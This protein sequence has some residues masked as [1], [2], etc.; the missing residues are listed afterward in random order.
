[1]TPNLIDEVLMNSKPFILF[2]LVLSFAV[3][4]SSLCVG[5]DP[6]TALTVKNIAFSREEG[7]GEKVSLFCDQSCVPELSS[8]EGDNPRVVMDMKGVSLIQTKTRNVNTGGT[9]V[10]RVRSYL[11]KQTKILRVVLDMEPSKYYTVRPMQDPSGNTYVLTV[12]EAVS[13]SEQKPGGGKD[14]KGSTLSQE[15]RITILSP[16]LKPGDQGGKL[17][18]AAPSPEK[19][20][21]VKAAKDAP[22]VDQGRSQLNAGEFA[23]AIDT[24]TRIIVADPQN[25]LSYRL[26]GNAYDN[27][28][29]RKKALADW[30]RAARLGDT[31]IQ[32]YLD[33][34]KVKWRGKPAP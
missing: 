10:K 17:Q 6:K 15:K 2:L 28:A 26:R 7:R 29:D 34:L 18:E 13:P 32:S 21:V 27:L 24:F 12:Y 19:R 9:L 4:V 1:M 25:S 14:A 11:D 33:F 23:A 31:T 3:S 20:R 8:F 30:K 5:E 16:D 22:S